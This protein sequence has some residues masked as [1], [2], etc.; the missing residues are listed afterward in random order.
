MARRKFKK[1][2]LKPILDPFS[3]LFYWLK[4]GF[5]LIVLVGLLFL[6]FIWMKNFVYADSYFQVNHVT[7]FPSGVLSDSEYRYLGKV[8]RGRSVFQ[9]DL[10]AISKDL[11]RNP[12]VKSAEVA[13][14]LP[15]EINVYLVSREPFVQIRCAN[16]GDY[17][18]V[19]KDQLVVSIEKTARPDLSLIEDYAAKT[20]K[21]SLGLRYQTKYFEQMIEM[22]SWLKSDPVW[23]KEIVT[24]V[25][26]DEIGNFIVV[27]NDGLE[28]KLGK[29][30]LKSEQKKSALKT[31][32][33]SGDRPEMLYF[34]LR[35]QDIIAKKKS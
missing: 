34:D 24:K 12:I 9:V 11:M 29:D 32:L 33:Q 19:S 13:R 22:V 3:F 16:G 10:N 21:Y 26:V 31:I 28:L 18:V 14:I 20:K 27:L 2:N 7:V 35:Y 25:M 15:N 6:A 8:T 17:Y 5:P 4:K 23:A 30:L 1:W